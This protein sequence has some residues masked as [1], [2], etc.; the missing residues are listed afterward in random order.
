MLGVEGGRK[1]VK[2]GDG[3][4]CEG[5]AALLGLRWDGVFILSVGRS[6]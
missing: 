5:L 6:R 4:L 3:I 1:D 2:D